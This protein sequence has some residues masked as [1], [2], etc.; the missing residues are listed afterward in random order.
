[1]APDRADSVEDLRSALR[2]MLAAQRRLRGRD[3]QRPEALSF[4]RYAVL[5]TLADGH[6][7]SAGELAVAADVTP[8]AITKL[9]DALERAGAVERT[10]G[11][12]DRRRIGVRITAIGR[13]DLAVKEVA[14]HAAWEDVLDGVALEQIETTA[15][16]LRRVATLFDAF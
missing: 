14:I 6:E 4:S 9:L 12:S 11:T 15:A 3:A 2:E 8:A 10:R 5:R 1:M 16:A 7:H 13:G